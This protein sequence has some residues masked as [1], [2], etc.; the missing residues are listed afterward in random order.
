MENIK[1]TLKSLGLTDKEIAVYIALLSCG[2][3][4]AYRIA[5]KSGIKPSTVYLTLENLIAKNLA[6]TLP[7]ARK[8]IF[9]AKNPRELLAQLE[10]K[11]EKTRQALPSMLALLPSDMPKIKVRYY[12]GLEGIKDALRYGRKQKYKTSEVVGFYAI[13]ENLPSEFVPVIKDHITS[14]KKDGIGMRGITPDHITTK[15]WVKFTNDLGH[16]LE[17]VP[18]SE[19][20]SRTSIEAEDKFVRIIMLK[21]EKALIIDDGE[22]AKTVKQIFEMVWKNSN[23]NKQNR[24]EI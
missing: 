22:L 1:N 8:Q 11:V 18:Y 5:E 7:K 19:Y 12:Q 16:A 4:P 6:Y 10:E 17:V 2:T 9:S 23:T 13:E 20:S 15:E 24:T 21:E 14:L 3:A